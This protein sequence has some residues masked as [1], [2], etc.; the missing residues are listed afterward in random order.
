MGGQLL[1]VRRERDPHVQ[2]VPAPRR[3]EGLR[4]GAGRRPPEPA[5]RVE[6]RADPPGRVGGR[7]RVV[8]LL[9]LCGRRARADGGD[10]A[11]GGAGAGLVGAPVRER[12]VQ[13]GGLPAL[14]RPPQRRGGGGDRRRHGGL[15]PREH[16]LLVLRAP[17]DRRRDGDGQPPRRARDAAHL[18]QL[19]GAHGDRPL[20][21]RP[22][23]ARGPRLHLRRV[24]LARDDLGGRRLGAADLRR[25]RLPDVLPVHVPCGRGGHDLRELARGLPVHE[26]RRRRGRGVPHGEELLTGTPPARAAPA[27]HVPE[28]WTRRRTPLGTSLPCGRREG[29]GVTAPSTLLA[30]P[31]PL[32][33]PTRAPGQR[34]ANFSASSYLPVQSPRS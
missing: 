16:E 24:R 29:R 8:P 4:P 11:R 26:D 15:R 21:S 32:L 25:L 14:V 22:V 33:S 18:Q 17:V 1:R 5:L 19:L 2:R 12:P 10:R 20:R 7:A 34:T 9:P 27:P 30:L 23:L 3:G 28:G 31:Q 13:L 6:R